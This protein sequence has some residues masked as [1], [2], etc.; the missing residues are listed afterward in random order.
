M[1]AFTEQN[2]L[3]KAIDVKLKHQRSL[4]MLSRLFT[5]YIIA[6]DTLYYQE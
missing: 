2:I 6:L 3:D 4:E 5:Y 1:K